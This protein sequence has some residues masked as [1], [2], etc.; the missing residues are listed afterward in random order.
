VSE[1]ILCESV[2]GVPGYWED[3]HDGRQAPDGVGLYEVVLYLQPYD[4]AFR[5]EW[6][7]N[8][9][10]PPGTAESA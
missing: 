6:G 7:G 1:Y 9:L 8:N 2:S 10:N 4:P 3:H 5:A